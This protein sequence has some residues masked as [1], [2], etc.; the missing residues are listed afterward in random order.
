MKRKRKKKHAKAQNLA[1]IQYNEQQEALNEKYAQKPDG[2]ATLVRCFAGDQR[3]WLELGVKDE[4]YAFSFVVFDDVSKKQDVRI[5]SVENAREFVT[6]HKAKFAGGSAVPAESLPALGLYRLGYHDREL[7]AGAVIPAKEFGAAADSDGYR[8]L[9][10]EGAVEFGMIRGDMTE[11]FVDLKGTDGQPGYTGRLLFREADMAPDGPWAGYEMEVSTKGWLPWILSTE[12][13][14]YTPEPGEKA[15]PESYERLLVGMEWWEE[16]LEPDDRL[17]RLAKAQRKMKRYMRQSETDTIRIPGMTA[18]AVGVANGTYFSKPE[19]LEMMARA[20]AVKDSTLPD[21]IHRFS[22]FDMHDDRGAGT[23]VGYAD[24]EVGYYWSEELQAV[25]CDAV[26]IDEDLVNKMSK[27]KE[28]KQF[29]GISPVLSFAK[30]GHRAQNI[31]LVNLSVVSYPAGEKKLMIDTS[32]IRQSAGGGKWKIVVV[33]AGLSGS[34]PPYLFTRQVLEQEAHK[35]E[36]VP[37]YAWELLPYHH[38]HIPADLLQKIGNYQFAKNCIGR[39]RNPVVEEVDGKWAIIADADVPDDFWNT[40]FEMM[41]DQYGFSIDTEG[42]KAQR[43]LISGRFVEKPTDFG[44]IIELT[45]VS[46][47]AAGGRV[48][49]RMA[50]S[51]TYTGR[52]VNKMKEWIL[53]CFKNLY[54]FLAEVGD[55]DKAVELIANDKGISKASVEEVVTDT[56]NKFAAEDNDKAPENLDEVKQ[57]MRDKLSVFQ[58]TGE[59][60][61]NAEESP[62]EPPA[63]EPPAE[64]PPVEE[65]PFD[66]KKALAVMKAEY[67]AKI[68]ALESKNAEVVEEAIQQAAETRLTQSRLPEESIKQIRSTFDRLAVKNQSAMDELIDME[69]DKLAA[70]DESGRIRMSRETGG[71]ARDLQF[72][73]ER[74]DRLQSALDAMFGVEVE[75]GSDAARLRQSSSPITSIRRAY[76][77]FTDGLDP[78][79]TGYCQDPRR[80]RQA[81]TSDFTY[82]LSVS[83]T[84]RAAQRYKKYPATWKKIAKVGAISNFKQQEIIRWGGFGVLET[85]TESDSSDLPTIGFP[86]DVRAVYTPIQKGGLIPVSRVAIKNDDMRLLQQIPDKVSDAAHETLNRFVFD[87]L[88]G[89]SSGSIN[90]QTLY[91]SVVTYHAYHGNIQTTAYSYQAHVALLEMLEDQWEYGAATAINNGAG[92][93]SSDTSIV[94]DDGTV[95]QEGDY[96]QIRLTGGTTREICYVSAVSTHTLT[97]TRGQYGTTAAAIA[98]DDEVR[99]LS[100]QLPLEMLH[101]LVYPKGLDDEVKQNRDTDKRPGYSTEGTN[102]LKGKFEA[103]K[104]MHLRGDVNNYYGVANPQEREG[105]VVEFVDGQEEPLILVQD[106][107]TAGNQFMQDVTTFKVRQE[108]G[109]VLTDE[110]AV[111]AG[112][113]A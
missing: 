110:T 13:E 103:I 16:G 113:V 15:V 109:G 35:F 21:D 6:E 67:D 25:L 90:A 54:S 51:A 108:Y 17:D 63:E 43:E 64:E 91:D 36:N 83:M 24:P 62:S 100:R 68:I 5:E 11:F 9:L 107:A 46:D 101:Y 93:L 8:I 19:L 92:Y 52:S 85:Y 14:G 2:Y 95:I 12:A 53:K 73:S 69:R 84:R 60:Q 27:T 59:V 96:I 40:R 47:A 30:K 55:L 111:A 87:I 22:I 97:V 88:I 106:A 66:A 20:N 98:D 86:G 28:V 44:K 41:S 112:I 56:V 80:L 78:N 48:L 39:T 81:T 1:P 77:L 99:V 49:H 32:R 4:G 34:T 70:L 105:I 72:G 82:A 3:N 75:Q 102:A 89:W 33:E 10:S 7:G 71:M 42:Y 94:V 76:D 58:P 104:S 23:W 18:W 65:I 50:A 31:D 74:Q 26:F 37:I 38:D 61:E 57:Y 29:F 79:V 45:C